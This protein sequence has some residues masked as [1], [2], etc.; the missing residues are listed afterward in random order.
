MAENI[1]L[2]KGQGGD[3]FAAD[4]IEGTKFARSKITIGKDGEND[5]DVSKDNPMP[6]EIHAISGSNEQQIMFE[7]LGE[8]R[9]LNARFKETFNTISEKE[10]LE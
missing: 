6:V 7:I 9:L 2:N 3:I 1:Q 10:D 4:D 5:G 8:L